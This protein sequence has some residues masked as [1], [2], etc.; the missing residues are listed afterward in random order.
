MKIIQWIKQQF[1][2]HSVNKKTLLI[3][4]ITAIIMILF[5]IIMSKFPSDSVGSLILVIVFVSGLAILIDV[6]LRE[7]TT[8]PI[9]HINN[10]AKKMAN[11]DFSESCNIKTNDE[12]E[13][14]SNNLN[15]MSSNLQ[16]TLAKLENANAQLE[17]DIQREHILL[18]QRKELVDNLSH[19]MKT[20]LGIIRAYAEGIHDE[21]DIHKKNAYAK[22]IIEETEKITDLINTLLDLSA[23]EAG[24]IKL[25]P[26]YFDIV[27]LVETV[28]GRL[29]IDSPDRNFKLSY[30][31]PEN[32][33]FVYTDK[34]RMHQVLNNL[35]LNS[36]KYVTSGREI[37]LS[38]KKENNL[39]TFNIYNQNLNIQNEDLSK[40]WTK[41]YRRNKSHNNNGSGLG[42]SIVAQILSM[43]DL[44]YGVKKV[45]NGIEF[46][47]SIPLSK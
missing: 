46:Y 14:L 11:L 25:Q 34:L 36:K 31:L 20:P 41:F 43:Q 38:L 42:L 9:I 33:L 12:F 30:E 8:K 6:L 16:E 45:D 44:E 29:L 3:S 21:P 2:L 47:F 35:I 26:E 40:I 7:I 19:E 13:T 24:A 23:L 39:A 4:K 22:I 27:E 18:I 17:K 5:Y 28:S 15:K 1:F 37:K 32:K 10:V